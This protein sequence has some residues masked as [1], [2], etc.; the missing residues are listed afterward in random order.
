MPNILSFLLWVNVIAACPAEGLAGVVHSDLTHAMKERW[1][2]KR[3][4]P[5]RTITQIVQADQPG[6]DTS[7]LRFDTSPRLLGTWHINLKY[8]VKRLSS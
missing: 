6:L 3:C 8:L 7:F 4:L 2:R 5:G 1:I